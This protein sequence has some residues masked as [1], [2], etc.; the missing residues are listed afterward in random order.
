M[1]SWTDCTAVEKNNNMGSPSS[2]DELMNYSNYIH[3]K[4]WNEIIIPL[5]NINAADVELRD[6]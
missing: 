2:Q 4:V 5:P 3:Y 6:G 1:F